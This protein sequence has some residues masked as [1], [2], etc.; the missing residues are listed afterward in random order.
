MTWPWAVLAYLG[1]SVLAGM[2]VGRRIETV[3]EFD[4]PGSRAH[5]RELS[6][7]REP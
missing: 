6:R 1:F 7:R 4:E 3:D 5:K 2:L